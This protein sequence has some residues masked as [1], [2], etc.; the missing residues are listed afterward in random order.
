MNSAN[1]DGDEAMTS[2]Y[3]KWS[4]HTWAMVLS[5]AALGGFFV[6]AP[7]WVC[8]LLGVAASV[9]LFLHGLS[10]LRRR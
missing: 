10:L 6:N 9:A 8:I 7:L 1:N 3:P 5:L 4:A 2:K